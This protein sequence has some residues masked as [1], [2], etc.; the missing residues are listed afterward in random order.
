MRNGIP[1]LLLVLVLFPTV[2]LFYALQ[3][4]PIDPAPY[5]PPKG[6]PLEGPTAPN[7]ELARL[8]RIG[9]G[10]MHGPEDVEVDGDGRIYAGT[11]DGRMRPEAKACPQCSRPNKASKAKCIYCGA[12]IPLDTAFDIL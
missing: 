4:S 2:W 11:A 7:R 12:E 3:G 6:P 10:L 9:I 1:L 5:A 8:D